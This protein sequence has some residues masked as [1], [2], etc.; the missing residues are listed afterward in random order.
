MV[1]DDLTPPALDDRK[2]ELP[3]GWT[4]W[5][6]LV[7][8][9]A[10]I[11]IGIVILIQTQDIRV[12]RAMSQVSPRAIPNLVGTCLIVIGLWYAL[13]IV[14]N[15]NVLSGGEDDEDIDADA[16]TDVEGIGPD[17]CRFGILRTTHEAGRVHHR[18]CRAVHHLL[19]RDG[20]SQT[21][22]ECAYRL[23][24]GDDYLCGVRY[25]AWRTPAGWHH[26]THFQIA[27]APT[28]RSQ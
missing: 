3:T 15:P 22:T 17:R 23:H 27:P 18:Q 26:G 8:A 19:I 24:S 4:R 20:K 7:L 2:E 16:P 14:R 13:D 25:L 11:I 6:E 10:L 21:A 1:M 28:S 5:S 12:V 9:A